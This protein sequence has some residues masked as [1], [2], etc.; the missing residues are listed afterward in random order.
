MAS[1]WTAQPASRPTGTKNPAARVSRQAAGA[2]AA[3]QPCS[4]IRGLTGPRP[5]WVY[6]ARP[7][8]SRSPASTATANSSTSVLS[9]TAEAKS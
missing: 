3:R 2:N 5:G 6:R 9:C 8:I 7:R 4:R 1:P